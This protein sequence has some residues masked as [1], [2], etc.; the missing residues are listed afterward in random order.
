MAAQ[1]ADHSM[2]PSRLPNMLWLPP[3][4]TLLRVEPPPTVSNVSPG[5]ASS[6]N[7]CHRLTG[8]AA[9]LQRQ[10]R[11]GYVEFWGFGQGSEAG[12]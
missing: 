2:P 3:R 12:A 8:R 4:L 7:G 5:A 1:L 6:S 10:V 11:R 9:W